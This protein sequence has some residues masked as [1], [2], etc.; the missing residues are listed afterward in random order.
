M[1]N[2]SQDVAMLIVLYFLYLQA[3]PEYVFLAPLTDLFIAINYGSV[4]EISMIR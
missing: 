1:R 4:N 3:Y 2:E